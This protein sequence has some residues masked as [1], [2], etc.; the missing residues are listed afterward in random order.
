MLHITKQRIVSIFYFLFIYCFCFLG[1]HLGH[2]KEVP[3][4]EVQSVTAA[5]IPTAMPDPSRVCNLHHSSPQHRSPDPLREA[6]D[7]ACILKDT[8]QI[9]LHCAAM[10]TLVLFILDNKNAKNHSYFFHNPFLTSFVFLLIHLL[11]NIQGNL[12]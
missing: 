1:L 9:R 10:G 6:R 11:C 4:L 5:S 12:L 8:S 7:Q 2:K 3:R